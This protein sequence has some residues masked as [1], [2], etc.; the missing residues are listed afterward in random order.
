MGSVVFGESVCGIILAMKA[1]M[2]E[3]HVLQLIL[4]SFIFYTFLKK[5]LKQVLR[6]VLPCPPLSPR[7][8]SPLFIIINLFIFLKQGLTL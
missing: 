1:E 4:G 6:R 2:G 8:Q 5:I 7:A 3:Y